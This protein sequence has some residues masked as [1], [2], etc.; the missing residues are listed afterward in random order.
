VNHEGL[1]PVE[2]LGAEPAVAAPPP[3]RRGRGLAKLVAFLLVLVVLFGG[4]GVY[5]LA[6]TRGGSGGTA[7]SVTIPV[8]AST[9][10]IASQLAKA[11]VIRSPWLFRILARWR[12]IASSLKPG[13]YSLRTHMSYSAVFTVLQKGPAVTFI[14]VTIP[15]GRTVGQIAEIVRDKLGIPVATFL[16]AA[17]DHAFRPDI[18]PSSAHDLEGVLFPDTYFFT[19]KTTAPQVVQR[20]TDEFSAKVAGLDFTAAAHFHVTPYQAL[21]VASLVEREAKVPGDRAKIASVIYNRL[22]RHM[23]LELDATVQYAI[24][25]KTGVMPNRITVD[26]LTIASP[27]NTYSIAG[28]PPGP[29]ASPGL[30]SLQAAIAPAS[31]NYLY[32]V[33]STDGRTH[34]FA[35]TYNEFLAYKNRT[36]SCA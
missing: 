16:A 23:Q 27:Y 3:R 26:D 31:T 22:S 35:T 24:Y 15:E 29:I 20:L 8:G 28:L 10:T 12:G 36:R 17:R 5:L 1:P 6:Q 2:E 19:D 21:I 25:L 32:Y 18:V 7:V 34:C 4:F 13:I 11:G 9:S 14:R 33:L 30:P